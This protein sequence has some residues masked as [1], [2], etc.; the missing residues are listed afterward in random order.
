MEPSKQRM[1]PPPNWTSIFTLRPDLDP[2]G[3]AETFI[4]TQE[5]PY[6]KPSQVKKE[7]KAAKRKAKSP[8]RNQI[9]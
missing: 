6:V 3:Y 4:H 1:S 9:T 2:P 5:N 7:E 8:G